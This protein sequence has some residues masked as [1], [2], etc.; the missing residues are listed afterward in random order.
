MFLLSLKPQ[1]IRRT[2]AQRAGEYHLNT[3]VSRYY[4]INGGQFKS[5]R[6]GE[7][8]GIFRIFRK[9]EERGPPARVLDLVP[10]L[11]LN[12]QLLELIFKILGAID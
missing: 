7:D 8:A 11:S 1:L 12:L 2:V 5:I 10:P 6:K 4:T 3:R 9:K